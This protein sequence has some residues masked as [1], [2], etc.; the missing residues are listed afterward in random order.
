MRALPRVRGL[1]FSADFF[2]GISDGIDIQGGV[3]TPVNTVPS[4][5]DA[6]PSLPPIISLN[7]PL[8]ID[9]LKGVLLRFR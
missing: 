7:P 9:K 1:A 3:K 4:G 5:G 6:N 8:N 2:D